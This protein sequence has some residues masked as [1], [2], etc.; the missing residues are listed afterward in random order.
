MGRKLNIEA[1]HLP[2]IM[3]KLFQAVGESEWDTK[4]TKQEEWFRA[5]EWTTDQE[6]EFRDWLAWYLITSSNMY[7][8][9]AHS[10][11]NWFVFEYGWKI[12]EDVKLP[13]YD[14]RCK[15]CGE[16]VEVFLKFSTVEIPKCEECGGEQE[17]WSS[18][19]NFQL[20]GGG[21]AKDGYK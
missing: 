9:M 19:M 13:L 1:K 7:A 2:V 12:K 20:K 14:L 15:E 21:W 17:K 3:D 11:A 18:K 6:I 8:K 5:K 16:E 10:A 4:L